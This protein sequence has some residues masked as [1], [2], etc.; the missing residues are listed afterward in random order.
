[1][2]GLVRALGVFDLKNV[3]ITGVVGGVTEREGSRMASRFL[4]EEP[5]SKL[6]GKEMSCL[7]QV[8]FEWSGQRR[9]GGGGCEGLQFME[10]PSSRDAGLGAMTT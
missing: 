2:E 8:A 3:I 1:M 4:T 10:A 6:V 9:S 7:R 5:S